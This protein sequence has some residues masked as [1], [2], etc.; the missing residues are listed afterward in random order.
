MPQTRDTLWMK[1]AF[2]LTDP[3]S[4]MMQHEI[5]VADSETVNEEGTSIFV[6]NEY[7]LAPTHEIVVKTLKL[8]HE[9]MSHTAPFR[10]CSSETCKKTR[11]VGRLRPEWL[12]WISAT[13]DPPVPSSTVQTEEQFNGAQHIQ[14]QTESFQQRF[15]LLPSTS[16]CYLPYHSSKFQVYKVDCSL[17]FNHW[18]HN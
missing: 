11:W 3:V 1:L 2:R 4:C 8:E 12:L 5:A 9:S 6:W 14:L 16:S 13:L 10:I 17:G 7:L 15:F 18:A